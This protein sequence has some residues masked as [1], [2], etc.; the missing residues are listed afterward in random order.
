MDLPIIISKSPIKVEVKAGQKYF[1]CSC[2]LSSKQPFCDGSHKKHKDENGNSI[3]KSI[4]FEAKQD[5][6]AF[7]CNCKKSKKGAI[8]DGSHKYL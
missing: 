3:M 8:C 2:G 6:F 4:E 7:F 5:G 1:W